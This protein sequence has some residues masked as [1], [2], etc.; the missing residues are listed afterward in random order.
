M[1]LKSTA[2]VSGEDWCG[3]GF[4]NFAY[5]YKQKVVAGNMA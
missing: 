1:T 3:Q 2:V 4:K 5:D